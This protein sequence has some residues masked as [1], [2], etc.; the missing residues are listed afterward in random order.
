[1]EANLPIVIGVTGHRNIKK[2]DE[3]ILHEKVRECITSLKE[4]YKNTRFYMLNSLASGADTICAEEALK[5]GIDIICP[6]PFLKEEYEKDFEQEDLLKFNDLISRTKKHF[7]VDNNIKSNQEGYLKAGVYIAENS[8]IIIAIWDGNPNNQ[9]N[10]GTSAVVKYAKEKSVESK[11]ML[12]STKTIPIYHI[13]VEKNNSSIKSS[14]EAK[15]LDKIEPDFSEIDRFNYDAKDFN[16]DN[17]YSIFP[18]NACPKELKGIDSIYKMADLLSCH[19]QK[20]YLNICRLISFFSTILVISYLLYD[21]GEMLFMLLIYPIT[22][23]IYYTVYKVANKLLIHKKYYSYRMFAETLRVQIYLLSAGIVRNVIEF[24]AWI[25]INELH[26]LEDALTSVLAI[27][28]PVNDI[29]NYDDL[30]KYWIDE[31]CS[32]HT[33][34]AVKKSKKDSINNSIITSMM[35]LTFIL[36]IIVLIMEFKYYNYLDI[37]FLNISI[38]SWTKILWGSFAAISLFS[39]NYYGK[40]SFDRQVSD[41][42]KMAKLYKFVGESYN[43]KDVDK[44]TLFLKLARE[45]IAENAE[46]MSYVNGNTFSFGI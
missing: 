22:L 11:K 31:Q 26:W 39:A 23:L 7:V 28:L 6:L 20:I 18:D 30:K 24:V 25:Q 44:K 21:E 33:N 37:E 17:G 1:M 32:Y 12:L 42:N 8:N 19:Y 36:Y 4:K 9:S 15:Y 16:A 10:C 35:I 2:E 29:L 5:T 14:F 34:S 45:E 27:N 13:K 3:S 41:H 43:I 46:W 38:R 40:L